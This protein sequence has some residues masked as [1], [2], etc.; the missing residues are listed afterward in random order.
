MTTNFHLIITIINSGFSEVVM[1]CAKQAGAKGGT[2]MHAR[3]TGDSEI[4]KLFNITI[5]P[6]KEIVLI[7]APE[8][9]R[10]DI[11]KAIAKGAGLT[12]ECK[13][14]VFALPIDETVGFHVPSLE[15]LDEVAAEQLLY[16]EKEPEVPADD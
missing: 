7:V 13:G 15:K 9:K 3:G 6:E 14:I 11:M 5:Q 8:T 12:T 1:N 2:V 4:A 16:A 10:H